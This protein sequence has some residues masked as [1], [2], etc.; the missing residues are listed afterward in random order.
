MKQRKGKFITVEGGEGAGKTT[1]IERMQRYCQTKGL[2]IVVTREPGG[3]K[4]A[5]HLRE[6]ILDPDQTMDGITEALLYAAARREHLLNKIVPAL[7]RGAF[8]MCD[9]YVDSSLAYQGYARGIGIDEVYQL[10]QFAIQTWMPDLTFYLDL[11]PEI[12]LERIEQNKQREVNRL[13]MEKLSFHQ[14]VREGYRLLR[15]RFPDRI[16]QIDAS[17]EF[18]KVWAAVQIH[19]DKVMEMK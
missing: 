1:L 5:E 9:R 12:G 3:V 7:E 17:E 16:I 14:K 15:D 10:N 4:L 11:P 18:S 6:L 2:D 8:V 19:L 13:D